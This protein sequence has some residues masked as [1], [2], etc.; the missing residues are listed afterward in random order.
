MSQKFTQKQR[1]FVEAY[2]GNGTEAAR[3]AGYTGNDKVLAQVATEN[4]RKP[5]IQAAIQARENKKISRLIAVRE[6][7]QEFWTRIMSDEGIELRD[8]LKASEL[9]GKSEADFTFKHE[10]SG[11]MTFD[12]V[13][14]EDLDRRIRELTTTKGETK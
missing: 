5:D 13:P 11:K 2:N 1:K 6:E 10:H 8:R 9:L 14:D 7:R 12:T 3:I 4:L